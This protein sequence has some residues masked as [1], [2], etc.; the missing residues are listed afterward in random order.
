VEVGETP[1]EAIR[2]E[3]AEE[4]GIEVVPTSR[5]GSVRV[6]RRYILAVW[7]VRHAGGT[8]RP[9]ASEVDAMRWLTPDAIRAA[10]PG[11]ASNDT[12]LRML[13]V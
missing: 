6:G 9:N 13:G 3:M 11:L 1:R 4:L 2:R 8:F 10:E 7:R 5:V 12:V